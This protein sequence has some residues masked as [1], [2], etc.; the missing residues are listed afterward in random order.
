VRILALFVS[1]IAGLVCGGAGAYL[2]AHQTESGPTWLDVIAHGSGIFFI[3]CGL[4]MIGSAIAAGS[5][6]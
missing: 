5:D 1:L 2:L 3:G 4:Y 6:R